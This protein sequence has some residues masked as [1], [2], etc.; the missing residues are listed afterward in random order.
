MYCVKWWEYGPYP[1][2]HMIQ[3]FTPGGS[4]VGE[5]YAYGECYYMDAGRCHLGDGYF[6]VPDGPTIE[7]LTTAGAYVEYIWAPGPGGQG[8][9]AGDWDGQYYYVTSE[10]SRGEF[11][12]YRPNWEYAGPWTI[13]GWPA[14]MTDTAAVAYGRRARG[15]S[16]DYLMA[17]STDGASGVFNINNGSCLGTWQMPPAWEYRSAAYGDSS[18]PGQF[19]A[20]LWVLGYVRNDGYRVYEI[21]VGAR[22]GQPVEPTSMGKIKAI[23]R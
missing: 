7:I 13:G 20:A 15:K 11:R 4:L 21:D 10:G 18:R 17:V 23:Y 5:G 19:G 16:G 1:E 22:G 12:R 14:S 2:S 3:R 9:N 8:I 6:S